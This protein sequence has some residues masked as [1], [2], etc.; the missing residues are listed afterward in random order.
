MPAKSFL[1]DVQKL[2]RKDQEKV[3]KAVQK[4]THNHSLPGL[5]FEKLAGYE[6]LWSIRAD[7]SLRILLSRTDS[8][9][10]VVWFL[11]GVGPHD[12]YR[13]R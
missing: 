12:V 10:D 1:K 6:N 3:W 11:E 4:F 8:D 9:G 2:D 5:N 13:T 7:I